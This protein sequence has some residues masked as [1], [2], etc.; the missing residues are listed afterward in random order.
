MCWLKGMSMSTAVHFQSLATQISNSLIEVSPKDQFTPGIQ[1]ESN[2]KQLAFIK[3]YRSMVHELHNSNSHILQSLVSKFGNLVVIFV[4]T[5]GIYH[6][7]FQV[8]SPL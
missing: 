4:K 2:K 1:L 5:D 7:L 6:L 8:S 3:V